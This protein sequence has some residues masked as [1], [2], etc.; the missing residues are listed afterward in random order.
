MFKIKLKNVHLYHE[1]IIVNCTNLCH[2]PLL[3]SF[4]CM[5][6]WMLHGWTNGWVDGRMNECLKR[7]GAEVSQ[8][9]PVTLVKEG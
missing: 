2:V 8:H 3:S 5:D 7:K 4:G 9:K 6:R 1:I